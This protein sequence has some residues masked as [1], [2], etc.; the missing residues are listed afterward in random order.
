MQIDVVETMLQHLVDK[1]GVTTVPPPPESSELSSLQDAMRLSRSL[2]LMLG[3][4]P[5]GTDAS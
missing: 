4:L 1:L 2:R 5:P 3:K